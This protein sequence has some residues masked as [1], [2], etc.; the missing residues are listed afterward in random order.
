MRAFGGGD[1]I[2]VTTLQAGLKWFETSFGVWAYQ[3]V[4]GV[5]I[6][7][8]GPLCAPSDRGE[9]LRRFLARSPRPMLIRPETAAG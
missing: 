6:T 3:H 1:L 4:G 7:L 5:D 2:G 8:G 9:M